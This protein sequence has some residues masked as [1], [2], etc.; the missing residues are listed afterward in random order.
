MM[1]ASE[2]CRRDRGGVKPEHILYMAMKI[3]RFRLIDGL[4]ITIKN[5]GNTSNL[6]RTDVEDKKFIE[7]CV[8]RNLS[9]MRSISNSIQY[10]MKRKKD[11]SAMIYQLGKPTFFLTLSSSEYKWF[12]LL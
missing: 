7:S 12:K 8:K 5:V 9:F 3:V 10:W 1:T 6:T 4:Y 2:I 11:V